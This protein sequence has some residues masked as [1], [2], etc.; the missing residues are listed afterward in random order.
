MIGEVPYIWIGAHREMSS[1]VGNED[2]CL[3]AEFPYG[4]DH[5]PH[6]V[7]M[8]YLLCFIFVDTVFLLGGEPLRNVILNLFP[9][10]I[11]S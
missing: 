2:K 11:L 9:L 8:Q 6:K 5:L 7:K 1:R 3:I 10:D 4:G